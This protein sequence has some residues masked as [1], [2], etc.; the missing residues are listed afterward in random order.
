MVKQTTN[1]RMKGSA[2]KKVFFA[3][4][5]VAFIVFIAC[6]L[7][8][9]Y[10]LFNTSCSAVLLDKNGK[11]LSASIAEDG[12]WRFPF[13]GEVPE[14]FVKCITTFE[15]KRFYDH[16]GIDIFATARASFKNIAAGKIIQGGSTLTMQVVRISRN[17]ISRNI[18]AKCI[19]SIQALRLECSFNKNEILAMY[20]S[21]APFGGNVVGLD[22]AAW[23]YFGRSAQMLSWG[24]MAALAVLP[25]AP[26]L[27]YPGRNR[28]ILLK[29]RNKL[30]DK[31]LTAKIIDA[32]TASLSKLEPL[33]GKPVPLPQ[34]APH[35]LQRYKE[36]VKVNNEKVAQAWTT[37]DGNLQDK[38]NTILDQHHQALKGNNIN[39]ACALVLEVESGNVLAYAGN[40]I[41]DKNPAMESY[42]DVINAPR[43]PGSV[44][45]PLLYAAMFSEGSI[46]PDMLLP[47]VPTMIGGYTPKNFDQ[48][49]DGAVP[50]S[51]ALSRSL[52]IPAVKLLQQY[53]YKRFYDLLKELGFSTLSKNADHYGL[54][55]ILGGGEVNMWDL[56]GIY[57][58]LARTLNHQKINQGFALKKD[59]YPPQFLQSQQNVNTPANDDQ[60][61][62]LDATS[63]WFT[64][65]AMNE[66]MRPEEEGLWQ[67]FSSS[68]KIA[69]KTGTSFGFRD[70]W[71][72][73]VT[74]R[75]VVAV[76]VGNT[77]GE[78]RPGLIGVQTAA[79]ILFDIFRSLP[80]GP[81]FKEPTNH[82]SFLPVCRQSGFRAGMYC[83][84]ADTVMV[85]ENGYRSPL[86][87][88]HKLVH[89]NLSG[90]YQVDETCTSP[91][92]MIHKNWLILPPAMDYYYRQKNPGFTSLP[93]FRQGCS[94]QYSGSQMQLI[95]PEK[96]SVIYMPIEID[97]NPGKAI[98]SAAHRTPGAK[99][100]WHLDNKFLGTTVDFHQMELRPQPGKHLLTIVDEHGEST[101][102]HINILQTQKNK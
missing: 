6:G 32:T 8:F 100:F 67:L 35:L 33:P 28:E 91:F 19:E 36:F 39:N 95:Y 61:S 24:E 31:L 71:A 29:K 84:A 62:G 89:L 73:G 82:F 69:W 11:L 18:I 50:A 34:A 83:E 79:P 9:P 81:W 58:G 55:M 90:N 98:F 87:P 86:C 40:I 16:P 60:L 17:G 65:R 21:E 38:I 76:W 66:V 4:G 45:K 7:Y 1:N 93:P 99:I 64:F 74:P 52:N 44:L 102:R 53:K 101:S 92:E 20:A 56:A 94:L 27:V 37:I 15:D 54:S 59:F 72:V 97:G 48:Q 30:I 13:N 57:A 77:N 46:L 43:S 63:I 51:M 5:A 49:Y 25:N 14:K 10:P 85:S 80:A 75:Y 12:Q 26:S 23:R 70:A 78:G 41:S 88:Y 3:I 42:V 47:D 68:Q 2:I 96:G 22:A